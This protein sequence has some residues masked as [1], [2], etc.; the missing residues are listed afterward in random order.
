M[1]FSSLPITS[2][3]AAIVG[4]AAILVWRVHESTRPVTARSIVIPPLAMSTGFSMFAARAFRVPWP[5]GI[6]AFLVG[7]VVFGYPIAATSRLTREGAVIM[8][9]RSRLFVAILLGLAAVRIA[10]RSYVGHIISV[11]QTAGLFFIIAFG[12]IVRWRSAMFL[13][14]RRLTRPVER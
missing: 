2:I 13:E 7:A 4:A 3:G 10:L 9:R 8:M 14:Y 12:M 11:E 1:D 5:W 6:G